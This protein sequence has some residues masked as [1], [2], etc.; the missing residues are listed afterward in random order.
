L[1]DEQGA[2]ITAN[3]EIIVFCRHHSDSSCSLH[4]HVDQNHIPQS[5]YSSAVGRKN[6]R[7]TILHL[8]PFPKWWKREKNAITH[9]S[10]GFHAKLDD[11]RKLSQALTAKQ[12][13]SQQPSAKRRMV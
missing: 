13:F 4:V 7:R 1:K 6:Q 12:L 2:F 3:I 9:H 5:V 8:F 11:H 10:F